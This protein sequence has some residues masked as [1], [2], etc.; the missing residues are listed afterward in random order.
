MDQYIKHKLKIKYYVRYMDDFI[1]LLDTKQQC[2]EMKDKISEF[3]KENLHLELNHKSRYYPC[4]QGVNFCG[5]R[6]WPTHR[7][8][9]TRSK[10]KIK[11]KIRMWN[12]YWEKGEIDFNIVAPSL[13]SWI[14]HA[15]HC[16]SYLIK[17]K[18]LHMAKFLYHENKEYIPVLSDVGYDEN[19]KSE[20]L[21]NVELAKCYIDMSNGIK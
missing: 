12:K 1:L 17:K 18:V 8:L 16:N 6:I 15:S 11:K 10:T 3:L 20:F 9:R 19:L 7:L 5:F 2:R 14:G 13:Q 21:D 4:A